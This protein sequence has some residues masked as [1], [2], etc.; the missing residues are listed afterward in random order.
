MVPSIPET[1][2]ATEVIRSLGP[3]TEPDIGLS[4]WHT[5]GDNQERTIVHT[6]EEC[7]SDV[8][9]K[10]VLTRKFLQN[11]ADTSVRIKPTL[12]PGSDW[13]RSLNSTRSRETEVRLD[14]S[15]DCRRAEGVDLVAYQHAQRFV[16]HEGP[17]ERSW[18]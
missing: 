16:P 5:I 15:I 1:P 18:T 3:V 12:S 6:L 10:E 14:K 8:G 13:L 4:N 9:L 2:R 7:P 17:L 11:L